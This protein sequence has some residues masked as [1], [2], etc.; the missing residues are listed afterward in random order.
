M[1]TLCAETR[2][3]LGI[4]EGDELIGTDMIAAKSTSI[5]PKFS[6]C[7]QIHKCKCFEASQK[8]Q[9]KDYHSRYISLQFLGSR[10][11]T[12][13]SSDRTVVGKTAELLAGKRARLPQEEQEAFKLDIFLLKMAYESQSKVEGSGPGGGPLWTE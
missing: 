10:Y 13:S 12:S 9:R 3:R 8:I 2:V 11:C 1:A 5:S 4:V 7:S 6:T